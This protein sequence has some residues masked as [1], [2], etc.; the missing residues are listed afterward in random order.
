[1]RQHVRLQLNLSKK[2]GVV[3]ASAEAVVMVYVLALAA[4]ALPVWLVAQMIRGHVRVTACCAPV[5]AKDVDPQ[6]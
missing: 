3:N 6:S 5:A 4:V 1:M 2:S